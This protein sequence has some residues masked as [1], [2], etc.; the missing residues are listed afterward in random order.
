M[1]AVHNTVMHTTLD[2]STSASS[3]SVYNPKCVH[4]LDLKFEGAGLVWKG[5]PFSIFSCTQRTSAIFPEGRYD[6]SSGYHK[7]KKIFKF[8]GSGE[9]TLLSLLS[10]EIAQYL[11]KLI[12]FPSH[13]ANHL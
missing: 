5:L 3:G 7:N 1:I 10:S 4:T 13:S 12:F 8:I 6:V 9:R 2:M 11:D